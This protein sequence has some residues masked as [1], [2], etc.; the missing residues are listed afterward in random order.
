MMESGV[1]LNGTQKLNEGKNTIEINNN[2]GSTDFDY[3][4]ILSKPAISPPVITPNHNIFYKS[5]PRDIDIAIA[6][7]GHSLKLIKHEDQ[8]ISYVH[9]PYD[10]KEFAERIQITKETLAELP[11]GKNILHLCFNDNSVLNFN[12][13]CQ[14]KNSKNIH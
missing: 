1:V 9:E 8:V 11:V 5:N 12:L 3:L 10:Y 13:D 6:L 2:W 14:R 4:T 7:N